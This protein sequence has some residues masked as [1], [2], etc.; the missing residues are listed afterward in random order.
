MAREFARIRAR[1]PFKT[2]GKTM[3]KPLTAPVSASTRLADL[4]VVRAQGPD[5]VKFLQGQLSN[6]VSALTPDRPLLAGLHNPQGRAIALLR[7][8][9]AGPDDILAVVPRE[10][11]PVVVARLSKFVLRA[12][13]KISDAS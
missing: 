2:C 7:L 3:L 5:V 1:G 9:L 12:K 11:V 10:L 6:D 4:S 8:M 13:V